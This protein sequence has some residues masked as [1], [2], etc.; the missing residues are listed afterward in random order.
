M[1]RS[2]VITRSCEACG[3]AFQAKAADIDRGWGRFCSK[4]CKAKKPNGGSTANETSELARL[5]K[6]LEDGLEY[7]GETPIREAMIEV[8]KE[9]RTLSKKNGIE[10]PP[11]TAKH[12]GQSA[13]PDPAHLQKLW[14][15]EVDRRRVA[16]NE[17]AALT[18]RWDDLAAEFG[19][20]AGE[21]PNFVFDA[22]HT[23]QNAANTVDSAS[24]ERARKAYSNATGLGTSK[25]GM[26]AALKAA[27]EP[28]EG[29][30]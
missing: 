6:R 26:F 29:Q 24:L 10:T 30:G 17:V 12:A 15:D 16:E 23:A 8:A 22:V 28:Q 5:A 27:R 19:L 3:A 21:R 2:N 9:L 1:A 20:P 25:T 18:K 14:A 4:S 13:H 7:S 11:P